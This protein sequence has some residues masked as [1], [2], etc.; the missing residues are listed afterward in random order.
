VR[1]AQSHTAD[2]EF[3]LNTSSRIAMSTSF[4]QNIAKN[5][6]QGIEG[7]AKLPSVVIIQARGQ[8]SEVSFDIG[9]GGLENGENRVEEGC[10]E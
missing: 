6:D 8:A 9:S 5:L 10:A 3:S 7:A 4:G 1:E 2:E